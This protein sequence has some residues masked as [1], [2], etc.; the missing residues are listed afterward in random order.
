MTRGGKRQGAGRKP[1]GGKFGEK[2]VPVRLPLSMLDEV[3]AYVEARGYQLPL[4]ESRVQAGLPSPA[5]DHVAERLN[6]N[7]LL[8]RSPQATFLVRAQGQSMRDAGIHDGDLMVVDRSLP[9]VPGK[10]VIAVLDGDLTV[11]RLRH[12]RG[13][14]V[15]QAENPDYPDIVVGPESEFGIWGVVTNVIH[16]V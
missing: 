6:V 7:D 3:Q 4:Y 2:T 10:I 14:V 12:E 9:A 16:P 1:G 5:D 13:G 8:V 15:L 11:K